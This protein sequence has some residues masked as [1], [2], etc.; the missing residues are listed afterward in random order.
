LLSEDQ[1]VWLFTV[2]GTNEADDVT[3]TQ[4]AQLRTAIEVERNIRQARLQSWRSPKPSM[5]TGSSDPTERWC[6]HRPFDRLPAQFR[7]RS[8]RVTEARD[9]GALLNIR[10]R[11][12][13]AETS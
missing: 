1:Q 9:V 7:T 4:K 13:S 11:W 5:K 3:P 8:M 12:P 10:N 2:Y 6:A